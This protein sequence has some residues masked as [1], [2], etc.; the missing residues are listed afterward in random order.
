MI[1]ICQKQ[2]TLGSLLLFLYTCDKE[3]GEQIL[4]V[5]A[6]RGYTRECLAE[7]VSISPKFLYEMETGKKGFSAIVLY[8]LCVALG[9]DSDYILTGA[10]KVECDYRVVET[11]QIF[12][13]SRWS[14]LVLS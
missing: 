8:N 5:R 3:A 2:I 12:N 9:V 10:E 1:R 14:V 13:S 11:L 4:L 6:M 7:I